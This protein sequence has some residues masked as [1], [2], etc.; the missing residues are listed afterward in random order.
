MHTVFKNE[1]GIS[2]LEVVV[3]LLLISI[4][5]ISFFGLFIQS[6][7]TGK[8]SEEIVDATYVAQETMEYVYSKVSDPN[9][10]ALPELVNN[11]DF[12][13]LYTGN[14]NTTY[15]SCTFTNITNSN[16]TIIAEQDSRLDTNLITVITQV[17]RDNATTVVMEAI[18]RWK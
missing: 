18:W 9:I 15:T 11:S 16:I 3:S 5:L 13:T 12:S 17:N 8:T 10:N 4:I 14:C 7:K 2:L 6:K 1:R